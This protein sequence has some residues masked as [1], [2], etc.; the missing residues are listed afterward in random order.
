M[1]SDTKI[2]TT[3]QSVDENFTP[4]GN[5]EIEE[6]EQNKTFEI[7]KIGAI[8][9]W[10]EAT[11]TNLQI[12]N[13]IESKVAKDDDIN[14]VAEKFFIYLQDEIQP[15]AEVGFHLAGYDKQGIRRLYHIFYGTQ[16]G[17]E[18][19]G[20]DFYKNA[21]DDGNKFVIL[22]NGKNRYTSEAMMLF[23]ELEKG[24]YLLF[25]SKRT[26]EETVDLAVALINHTA[27]IIYEYEGLQSVGGHLNIF[28][29][30]LKNE[31][32]NE[33][34]ICTGDPQSGIMGRFR[35]TSTSG[36]SYV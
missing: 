30:N 19:R 17:E 36:E 25:P 15:D 8:S 24:G 11:N 29:V 27:R 14:S 10:G 16:I 7:A 12:R 1:V 20:I 6:S 9:F 26:V 5:K 32:R 22:F 21:E 13:F 28:V 18:G 3:R 2:I 33:Q 34:R 31:I 4:I 23:K 35:V